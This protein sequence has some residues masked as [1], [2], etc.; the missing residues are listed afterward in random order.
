MMRRIVSTSVR[1]RGLL[2]VAVVAVVVLGVMEFRSMPR[3]VLPEFSRPTVEVQTEALGLA[4]EE[5]EQ[6]ITVPLEQDL[7]NGVAFLDTIRSQSVPG[8]SRIELVFEK[9]TSLAR[10]R[11]VV[12]ER[13]IQAAALPHV[14]APPQ[15][16]Q[17]LASESRVMMVRLS[18][19]SSSL[20]ELGTLARWTIRP[21]L[22]GVSGVADVAIW[23]QREQQVQVQV[24][25]A[26][27]QDQAVSLDQVISTAGNALWWS[28]LGRLEANTPG[29]GGFIDGAQQRL[30]ILHESPIKTP[31]DL[32]KVT[33]EAAGEGGPPPGQTPLALGDVSTL[34]GD[35]QPL[36]GDAVFGDGNGLL[37]VI[38][39]LPEANVTTV[40]HG[41]DEALSA[42]RPGL[43]GVDIDASIFRP[44]NYVDNSI[45]G[46]LLGL[47]LGML[48]LVAT[49]IALLLEWRTA[50]I[51]AVSVFVSMVSAV[52]VLGIR[53]AGLNAMVLAGLVLAVAV[54]VDDA[55]LVTES[56]R[57]RLREHHPDLGASSEA[58]VV[59]STLDSRGPITY[60]AA[61]IALAA[62]PLVA[63]KGEGG[64]FLPTI[65][66]SYLIAI[67]AAMV[68][69]LTVSPLLSLLLFRGRT[70]DHPDSPLV[71]R[72]VARYDRTAPRLLT[73]PRTAYAVFGALV[74]V[75][76][77]TLPFVKRGD[78]L[79][80]SFK[81]RGVLVHWDGAPGT[82]LAEMSRITARASKELQAL[83]GVATVGAHVGRAV[84]GDQIV[85][86][87][88]GE[89]WVTIA[90]SANYAR[91]LRAIQ[92]VVRGYPG[93]DHNVITYP[94]E[95]IRSILDRTDH[96]L[97][98]RIFGDN[99]TVLH[100]KA[101][102]VL[103]AL[104]AIRGVKGPAVRAAPTE[105]SLQIKVNL[106][107]AD[108]VGIK[109]GDVRRAVTTLVSGLTVGALFEE[110]KVFDVVV[111]GAPQTRS[112]VD[113]IRNLL[114]DTPAGRH[115]RVRD[116]A[117]VTIAP[118][119]SVIRHEDVSR[120]TD[121]VANVSGRST[122]SV[123]GDVKKALAKISFPLQH[124][125]EL[126]R[127]YTAGTRDRREFVALVVAAMIGILL[128]F[129][130]A[131]GSWRLA[132]VTL[133]TLPCA[134]AGAAVGAFVAGPFSFG[135]LVGCFAVFAI[136]TRS[137]LLLVGR[138]RA[139]EHHEPTADRANLVV[140]G[141]REAMVP[142]LVRA[143]AI[144]F[145]LLPFVVLSNLAGYEITHRLAVVVVSGLV[146]STLYGLLVVPALYLRFSD[147]AE[148]DEIEKLRHDVPAM[149]SQAM[150]N[151]NGELF[152]VAT[153]AGRETS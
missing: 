16:L 55:I 30:G 143:M 38:E 104:T 133:V 105:P 31:D 69:A 82:S 113:A 17:P 90:P 68:V 6:L 45:E 94:S 21:R 142:M 92:A 57:H 20:T 5:V 54:V 138:Y 85:G 135:S 43:A 140:L 48:L 9:G 91:T 70:L 77:V 75:G 14:S 97:T 136:A 56:I 71:S 40:T 33:V 121:V 103:A 83:D 25:P 26:R 96:D 89:M 39:K 125:A 93:L 114:I 122:A 99:F 7:L 78:S 23:G 100:D 150:T 65:V 3:D 120:Y 44:A 58:V 139:L 60:A 51:V 124:R 37:L 126:L 115:V 111:V 80:P 64:A 123:A 101:N 2:A 110:Q 130:A 76:L 147:G 27:L 50:V 84:G 98:V 87:S 24:D 28:P 129:Q 11:Q 36:I 72:L 73:A 63:L 106:D 42:L 95:R 18:S 112:S 134:M 141:T 137:C 81:D 19:S 22:M 74:V 131:F 152:D 107:T 127:D 102:E 117:D 13:L 1:L 66:V 4:A 145:M 79:V 132:F 144:G 46:V 153:S 86:V 128:L 151:G 8:L 52:F 47:G 62:L 41:V 88:S 116:V 10:A 108:K 67:G 12:N 148:V 146:T 49:L 118:G 149:A 34:V 109:P 32:S 59:Q 61:I 15:M 53:G 29:T 119:L 35:H